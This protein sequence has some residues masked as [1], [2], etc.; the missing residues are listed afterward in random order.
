MLKKEF[1]DILNQKLSLVND[2]EREDILL[3]YGTYI[4]DKMAS[5]VSEEEAVAGFGDVDEL[6]KEILDAYKINTDSMDPLSSKADK[7]IDKVY[8]KMEELF[9]RLGNFSMNEIF[10]IFFDAI[11]LVFILWIGKVIIVEALC[12]LCL[13]LIFSFFVGFYG[14]T[15][16][17]L[18]LCR[19]IYL[20]MAIYF[21]VKV[22]AKRI[23]R[24]RYHNQSVGVMDD[25]KETWNDN[26]KGNDLPPTPNRPLYHERK[27][28]S[29]ESDV[30]KVILVLA[31]IPVA[32]VLIG[33]GISFVV[34]VYVSAVY[35]TTSIG[36]YCMDIAFVLGSL[37]I[38]LMLFRACPKKVNTNA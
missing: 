13:S 14:V 32:C 16:F 26:I 11:V 34:L 8:A 29:I 28:R 1:L 5:G 33:S 17:L 30:L 3:E 10:H 37:T 20:C 31:M 9:S 18:G 23:E 38:L 19:I 12:N 2:K 4:D 35:A 22:M 25:I 36:I 21:F 7:T 6:V 27:S 24:Y 15:D